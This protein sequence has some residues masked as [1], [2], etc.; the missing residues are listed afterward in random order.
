MN[1]YGYISLTLGS[2]T[3][4]F[5]TFNTDGAFPRIGAEFP[6]P[7][8]TA[9]NTLVSPG[10]PY[11]SLEVWE[12][13]G[14]LTKANALLLRNLYREHRLLIDNRQD[15][16]ILLIDTILEVEERSPRTRAIA[17]APFN[18]ETT[19]GGYVSYYGQFYAAFRTPPEFKVDA[20]DSNGNVTWAVNCSLIEL[21]VKP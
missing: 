4:T 10:N 8:F 7:E 21:G 13:E 5:D 18:T 2:I 17:P 14:I 15:G 12:F 19:S 11:G 9:S 3:V 6:S 16:K 1:E 20:T